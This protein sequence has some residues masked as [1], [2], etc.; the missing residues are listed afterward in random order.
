[1]NQ[2][3]DNEAKAEYLSNCSRNT[4]RDNFRD[5]GTESNSKF[6]IFSDQRTNVTIGAIGDI[7]F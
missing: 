6:F 4:D 3:F 7:C 5:R 1:M 2:L